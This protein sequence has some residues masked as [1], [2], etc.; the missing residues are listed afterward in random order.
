MVKLSNKLLPNSKDPDGNVL[1]LFLSLFNKFDKDV[2][3]FKS[4]INL[5][6]KSKLNYTKQQTLQ[7]KLILFFTNIVTKLF[8][9]S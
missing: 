6:F 7:C 3:L 4:I 5:L 8:K 1:M 2:S 9:K